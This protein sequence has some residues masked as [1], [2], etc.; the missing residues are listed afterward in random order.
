[1]PNIKRLHLAQFEIEQEL[2]RASLESPKFNTPHEGYAVIKKRL[3]ELWEDI[4]ANRAKGTMRREAKQV[5]AMA[6]R[7][8]LDLCEEEEGGEEKPK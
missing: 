3:D 1:M 4:K 7:F 2:W 6:L 8:M 5:A